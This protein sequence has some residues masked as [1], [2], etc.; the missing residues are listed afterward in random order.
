MSLILDAL[1]KADRE[2]QSKNLAPGIDAPHAPAAASYRSQKIWFIA[3]LL[4][5]VIVLLVVVIVRQ[6]PN[7]AMPAVVQPAAIE[8]HASSSI[9]VTKV[10]L[11]TAVSKV[12]TEPEVLP[13]VPLSNIPSEVAQSIA[14][15]YK[16]VNEDPSSK[17][18]PEQEVTSLY[19]ELE[20]TVEAA[21]STP[22]IMV[23]NEETLAAYSSI[24]VIR[25]LPLS[26]QSG[27]PT[28][29]YSQHEYNPQGRSFI[30]INN[31]EI[32]V[33]QTFGGS[34]VLEKILADGIIVTIED[35]SFTLRALSSWV[36]L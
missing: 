29:M 8:N 25:D 12:Q 31:Q 15:Q 33:G 5:F 10:F 3:V 21:P 11:D 30:V 14:E 36:N 16:N 22:E 2:R 28:L 32:R 13:T 9:A 20:D 1:H 23:V 17:V 26:M 19:A 18:V 35:K 27:I 7:E 6:K 4:L 24:G 34:C